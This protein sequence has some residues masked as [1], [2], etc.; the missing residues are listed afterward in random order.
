MIDY[1]SMVEENEYIIHVL[2]DENLV[3][4]HIYIT[5]P[6][7]V[8]AIEG[9]AYIDNLLL[10]NNFDHVLTIVKNL[11][12]LLKKREEAWNEVCTYVCMYFFTLH[13]I[14][15]ISELILVGPAAKQTGNW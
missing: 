9:G 10:V 13:M 15:W 1:K 14:I 7:E 12:A 5:P 3:R 11:V 8:D 2:H 4:D 6:P